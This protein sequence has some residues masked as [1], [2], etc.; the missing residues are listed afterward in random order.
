MIQLSGNAT[1]I[2]AVHV[3]GRDNDEFRAFVEKHKG[4]YSDEITDILKR[5]KVIGTREGARAHYFKQAE[6]LPGDLVCA[7]YDLE[8][9]RLRLYCIRLGS[10]VIILGGGADKP[11]DIRAWQEKDDLKTAA[12]LMIRVSKDFLERIREKEIRIDDSTNRL[13][14]NLEFGDDDDED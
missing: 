12:K 2:Y 9:A 1:R 3:N 7:L 4:L 5:L 10:D 11:P 6:G 8:E 13:V 14:G